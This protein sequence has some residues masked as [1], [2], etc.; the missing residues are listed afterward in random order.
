MPASPFVKALRTAASVAASIFGR[1]SFVPSA[2]AHA[3]P[4]RTRSCI[5][6][7]S[8]SAN[9]PI[10]WNIASPAGVVVS[11]PCWRRYRSIFKAWITDRKVTKSCNE[12]PSRSHRPRHDH[13]ELPLGRVLAQPVELGAFVAALG[14]ADAVIPVDVHD[15]AAHA[16]GYGT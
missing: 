15:F 3:R 10:I 13:V 5:I 12:R 16:V 14:A 7:R 11:M 4:A 8:N 2:S 9:T 1:P 6:E